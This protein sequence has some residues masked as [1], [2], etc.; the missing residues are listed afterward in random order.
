MRP[1][2]VVVPLILAA[3]ALVGC[4]GGGSAPAPTTAAAAAPTAADA[5]TALRARLTARQLSL[6]H[7]TCIDEGV[8]RAGRTVFRCN[9]NFGEPHIIGYCVTV[10]DGVAVT[11]VEDP[12]L[13]CNRTRTGDAP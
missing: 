7:V 1:H 12:T 13:R 10:T 5:A 4:A 9:V 3:G 8:R 11:N 2:V 6:H